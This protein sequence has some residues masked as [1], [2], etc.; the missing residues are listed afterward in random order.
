MR[1]RLRVAS[2]VLIRPVS[3]SCLA[4]PSVR[5]LWPC[6]HG[7]GVMGAEPCGSQCAYT[8]C[9]SCWRGVARGLVSVPSHPQGPRDAWAGSVGA[10]ELSV[11]VD[12]VSTAGPLLLWGSGAAHR[13]WAQA[14][15]GPPPVPRE[16]Q[17]P[18][19]RPLPGRPPTLPGQL[20][21]CAPRPAL[22]VPAGC[23]AAQLRAEAEPPTG[24]RTPGQPR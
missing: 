14:H 12:G 20:R 18:A 17:P 3:T 15:P 2:A 19:Q 13:S 16:N 24:P 1:T 4:S 6:A 7:G 11:C 10:A 23:V 9:V 8:P 21:P 22:P 5:P